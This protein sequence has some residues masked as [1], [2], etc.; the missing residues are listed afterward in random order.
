MLKQKETVMPTECSNE[1][2][3]TVVFTKNTEN[4][5]FEL[6]DQAGN[7][8]SPVLE[9]SQSVLSKTGPAKICYSRLEKNTDGEARIH[10]N[11][12]EYLPL[13]D[14]GN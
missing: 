7:H 8:Y 13:P 12:I 10:V 9:S 4:P 6:L 5:S 11:H 14:A 2:E 3:V 1:M